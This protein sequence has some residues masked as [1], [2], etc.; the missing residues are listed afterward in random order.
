MP[1]IPEHL[2]DAERDRLGRF[3]ADV[4]CHDK[5]RELRELSNAQLAARCEQLALFV[6]DM[7]GGATA[8]ARECA[9]MMGELFSRMAAAE[10]KADDDTKGPKDGE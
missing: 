10:A 5:R 4:Q 7:A 9:L 2:S 8:T 3:S 1:R 6:D